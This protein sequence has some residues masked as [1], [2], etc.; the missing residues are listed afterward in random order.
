MK[1]NMFTKGILFKILIQLFPQMKL[2]KLL[3]LKWS[4]KELLNMLQKYLNF[5]KGFGR[6]GIYAFL[7]FTLKVVVFE[8]PLT[9]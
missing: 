3:S 4:D 9:D 6:T 5:Y 7:I 8:V 2:I 1:L